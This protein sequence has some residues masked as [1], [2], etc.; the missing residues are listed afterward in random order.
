MTR[1][2][3]RRTQL[4]T[5]PRLEEESTLELKRLRHVRKLK[6]KV[7]VTGT[8]GSGNRSVAGSTLSLR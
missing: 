7:Q 2:R 1:L 3:E 8:D 5:A 6:L 4:E